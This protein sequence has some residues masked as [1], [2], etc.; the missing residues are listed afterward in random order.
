[1]REPP[2]PAGSLHCQSAAA[3]EG[4]ETGERGKEKGPSGTE[5]QVSK[6]H[7][8]P[9]RFWSL[10]FDRSLTPSLST[11]SC[12]A[13]WTSSRFRLPPPDPTWKLNSRPKGK[14]GAEELELPLPP[15]PPG[16]EELE[17]PLPPPPPGAEELELPLPP[18][19]PGA[20]E[21]ELPLPP[22]PP[23]A[24]EL[25][26]PLPPVPPRQGVRWPEPQKGEL[27]AT[28]KGEVRRPSPNTALSLPE[29]LWPEPHRR[30]LP[31]MKKGE[32]GGPPA[33]AAF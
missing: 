4:P 1:M 25:E 22:P 32:V 11:L 24:E 9:Q 10:P 30:E 23:G 26:L 27:P 13:P 8:P 19:P 16:A 14:A 18:P 2:P 12:H 20:E 33:P 29:V 6:L 31:A 15:P 17:L 3:S 21:L 5:T 28:K 7:L